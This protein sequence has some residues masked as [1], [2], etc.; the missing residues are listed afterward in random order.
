MTDDR[1]SRQEQR[2]KRKEKK[3][4]R[5]TQHGKGIARVYKNAVLKR[6]K[7]KGGSYESS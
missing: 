6:I 3:R 4:R 7:K 2:E 1:E 5:M